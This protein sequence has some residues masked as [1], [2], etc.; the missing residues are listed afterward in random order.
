[1]IT[2][3]APYRRAVLSDAPS[4]AELVNFAG[5]GVPYYLWERMAKE[6]ESA[7]EVGRSRA[8]REQ[9][10][11]SFGTPLW[12]MIMVAQLPRWLG[13]RW[14]TCPSRTSRRRPSVKGHEC[15]RLQCKSWSTAAL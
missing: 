3:S 12:P 9:G 6:G 14:R 11:F 13:T 1:M 7:W 10:G 8:E 2:L 4:L 5:E 15:D